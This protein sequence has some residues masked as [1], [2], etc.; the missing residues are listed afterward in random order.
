MPLVVLN[1][2]LLLGSNCLVLGDVG[3]CPN[4]VP[5]VLSTPAESIPSSVTTLF[6]RVVPYV[7]PFQD[8]IYIELCMPFKI[9]QNQFLRTAF[10]F[11]HTLQPLDSALI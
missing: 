8:A 10:D 6:A 1:W 5:D 11:F 9:K 4:P 2:L 7:V 3:V